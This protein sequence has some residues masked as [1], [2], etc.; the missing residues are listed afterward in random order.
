MPVVLAGGLVLGWVG[1]A[2][3]SSAMAT[4]GLVLAALPVLGA[5]GI[6]VLA[7]F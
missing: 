1:F 5:V 4:A 7:G 2:R 3:G 6:L